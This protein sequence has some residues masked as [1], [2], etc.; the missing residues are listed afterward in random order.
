MVW[1]RETRAI[2]VV[3]QKPQNTVPGLFGRDN[4]GVMVVPISPMN[5]G[6]SVA[7]AATFTFTVRA[8]YH[9]VRIILD[10]P[11]D[12][13]ADLAVDGASIISVDDGYGLIGTLEVGDFSGKAY[14]PVKTVV[15]S[16][17]NNGAVAHDVR[18]WMVCVQGAG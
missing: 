14:Y 12:V 8:N 15:L 2:R 1:D 9:V 11:E 16:G 6:Q 4:V 17:V 5:G 7:A 3:E 13:D 18:A 10:I